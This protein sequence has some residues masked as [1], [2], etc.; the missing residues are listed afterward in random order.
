MKS[1]KILVL[2]LALNLISNCKNTSNNS[3]ATSSIITFTEKD[4]KF[5][6]EQKELIQQVVLESEKEIRTLLPTL[7]DSIQV[8]LEIVDWNLDVVGGVTG[9]T[10]TNSPPVV[11]IQISKNYPGGV[12]AA[13]H[14]ALKHTIFHEFH[15]LYRGWAIRDNKF[16]PGIPIAA[17]NEG[18]AVVFSEEYTSAMEADSPPEDEIAEQWVTEIMALPKNAD[19]QQWMFQHPDGRQSIGYRTGNYL[20]R[21]AMT[22]SRKSVL[23]LSELSPDEIFQL[24]GH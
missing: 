9:R 19:Y 1:I 20:I 17:I 10:E 2:F 13:T 24:A 12:A 23:E 3:E 15:H 6:T 18:L 4:G 14:K 7:P 16:G 5:T 11:F 22:R 8:S 21:K